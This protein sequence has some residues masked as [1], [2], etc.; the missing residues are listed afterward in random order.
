MRRLFSSFARGWPGTALLLMRLVAATALF[1]QVVSILEGSAPLKTLALTLLGMLAAV[2]LFAGLW[3]PVAGS[4][5]ALV[6]LWSLSL[7]MR[8]P[9][10]YVLL[11]TFGICLAMLGPGAWSVDAYLFGWKRID[12]GHPRS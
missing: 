6:E 7:H 1:E 2:L 10:N 11:G 9:W 12:L 8:D 5:A 4:V 3:T